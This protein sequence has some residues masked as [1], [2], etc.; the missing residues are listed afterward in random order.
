MITRS[1]SGRAHLQTAWLAAQLRSQGSA[2]CPHRCQDLS[3]PLV[4]EE[5]GS[6]SHSEGGDTSLHPATAF[7]LGLPPNLLASPRPFQSVQPGMEQRGFQGITHPFFSHHHHGAEPKPK[8]L[9]AHHLLLGVTNPHPH[10][11]DP[12]EPPVNFHRSGGSLVKTLTRWC[13]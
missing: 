7:L 12:H 3:H 11:A 2:S 4:T 1:P 8:H 10:K 13:L 5:E 9:P 6:W